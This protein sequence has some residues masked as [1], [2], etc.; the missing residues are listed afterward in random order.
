MTRVLFRKIMLGNNRYISKIMDLMHQ[1]LTWPQLQI[2]L[3]SRGIALLNLAAQHLSQ[4]WG[5]AQV[6]GKE[7]N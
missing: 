2:S 1:K 4:M 5:L 3:R 6:P 7:I